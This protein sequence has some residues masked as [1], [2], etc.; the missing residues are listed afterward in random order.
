MAEKFSY[1]IK[2]DSASGTAS[3]E[4][5]LITVDIKDH[6]ESEMDI[7][8][9]PGAYLHTETDK[10]TIMVLEGPLDELTVKVYPEHYRKY[11]TINS[12][13]YP[14]LYAKIHKSLYVFL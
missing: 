7:F 13:I 11:V 12:K 4:T 9:I 14:L 3:T 1:I 8:N 6:E 2:E 5:V 10:E